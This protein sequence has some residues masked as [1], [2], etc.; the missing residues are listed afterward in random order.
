MKN[1]PDVI[2]T[3]SKIC[4]YLRDLTISLALLSGGKAHAFLGDDQAYAGSLFSPPT[5][6]PKAGAF[7]VEPY[8]YI[9]SPIGQFGAQGDYHPIST[10]KRSTSFLVILKYGITSRIS[11]YITPELQYDWGKQGTSAGPQFTDLPFVLQGVVMDRQGATWD[12][13]WQH[14]TLTVD[15]GMNFPT[16]KYDRLTRSQNASGAGDYGFRYG[17]IDQTGFK[18][19][20]HLPFRIRLW[21]IGVQPVAPTS[22]QG[23]SVYGTTAEFRGTVHVEAFGNAGGSVEVPVTRHLVLALD[24]IRDWASGSHVSGRPFLQETPVSTGISFNTPA[25]DDWFAAPAIEYNWNARTSMLG[26]LGIT[27]AGRDTKRQLIGTLAFEHTF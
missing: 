11:A 6:L 10:S 16:G 4:R 7:Y 22:L 18:F 17:L 3:K 21:A 24:L 9:G 23:S 13:A 5:P 25:Q 15:I 2:R 27:L 14:T 1:L 19:G 8:L 12:G 26:G 20:R